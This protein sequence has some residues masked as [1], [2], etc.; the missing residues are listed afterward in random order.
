MLNLCTKAYSKQD[1]CM[2]LYSESDSPLSCSGM[3]CVS[4]GSH[5]F[6]CHLHMQG[7]QMEEPYLPL[8]HS[9]RVS[10]QL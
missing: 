10:P 3:A 5:S 7:P 6:T 4:K 8:L 9:C 2:T 1:I